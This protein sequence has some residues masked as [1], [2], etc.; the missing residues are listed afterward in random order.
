MGKI[1]R[2]HGASVST[3]DNKFQKKFIMNNESVRKNFDAERKSR[4][5]LNKA[6]LALLYN[7]SNTLDIG[8]G[9]CKLFG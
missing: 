2:K 6:E 7:R 9:A 3:S 1:R 5:E 4:I 8:C